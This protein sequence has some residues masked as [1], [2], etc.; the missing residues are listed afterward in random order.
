VEA[1]AARCAAHDAE[2]GRWSQEPTV[3]DDAREALARSATEMNASRRSLQ[4]QE[5]GRY[6]EP[7]RTLDGEVVDVE[8]RI[9]I[10]RFATEEELVWVIAH[11]L[12]HALGLGHAS[13][14]GAIMS[15][16][17]TSSAGVV[18][19]PAL[20]RADVEMLRSRCPGL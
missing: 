19:E 6:S 8:R 12:G 17:S 20:H 10:H 15:P 2:V 7:V 5:E 16:V 11:E 9:D 13:V 4:S 14:A 3:P 1:R 18:P